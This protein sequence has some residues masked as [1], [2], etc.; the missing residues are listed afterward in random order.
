MPIPS[1]VNF[2]MQFCAKLKLVSS[3]KEI[4]LLKLRKFLIVFRLFLISDG[5]SY[6][7]RLFNV[8]NMF[9]NFFIKLEMLR[10]KLT[11]AKKVG[12]N[13]FNFNL[14]KFKKIIKKEIKGF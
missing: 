7:L 10:Q 2:I 8:Y 12:K 1:S 3:K 14:F 11:K 9:F 13:F 4:I 6:A 5:E